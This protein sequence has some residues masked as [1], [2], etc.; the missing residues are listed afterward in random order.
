MHESAAAL[1]ELADALCS[2]C[3][4]LHVASVDVAIIATSVSESTGTKLP[5][6]D[7]PGCPTCKPFR[8]A[9]SKII[10]ASN[11]LDNTPNHE[12]AL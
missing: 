9:V 3:G 7:C 1:T 6:C 5:W 12:D 4:G 8:D 11:Y 2:D 10:A